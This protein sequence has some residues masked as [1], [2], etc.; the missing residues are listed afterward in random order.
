[1]AN[2]GI[3]EEIADMLLAPEEAPAPVAP[4]P[5][6]PTKLPPAPPGPER[7][8]TRPDTDDEPF[9]SMED[10]RKVFE[11][12][13]F[14]GG[15]LPDSEPEPL[16]VTPAAEGQPEATPAAPAEGVPPVVPPVAPAPQAEVVQLPGTIP[17][18]VPPV[19]PEPAVV[20]PELALLR[21]TIKQQGNQITQLT[22]ALTPQSQPAQQPGQP[23]VDPDPLPTYQFPIP[24][25]FMESWR[26]EDPVV[27]QQALQQLISSIGRTVHR[28]VRAEYAERVPEM[29][30]GQVQTQTQTAQA[31]NTIAGDFYGTYPQMNQP[32]VRP[33]VQEATREIL[34]ETRQTNWNPTMRDAIAR[35]VMSKVQSISALA[36]GQVAPG[37]VPTPSNPP[38]VQPAAALQ[39]GMPVAPGIIQPGA[40]PGAPPTGSI[41]SQVRDMQLF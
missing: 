30:R 23:A 21:E 33:M 41:A 29:V 28:N 4:P 32:T 25:E 19:E 3:Q 34:A 22:Q 16:P 18:P 11:H 24:A 6:P 36:T 13:P 10:F 39:P 35:R 14:P 8:E 27:Q 26:S 31:S 1:M 7:Q 2:E 17:E 40:S 15:R 5:G 20:D 9:E 37:Q 12:D 38:V